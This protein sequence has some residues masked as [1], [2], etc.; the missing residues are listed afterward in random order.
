MNNGLINSA[1]S[2]EPSE[3]EEKAQNCWEF[4]KCPEVVKKGC[5]AYVENFGKMCWLKLLIEPRI[6]RGYKSCL[7][8]DWFNV[9]QVR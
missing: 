2:K 5:S 4:W 1:R 8:C 6:D 9:G 7:Q 3:V